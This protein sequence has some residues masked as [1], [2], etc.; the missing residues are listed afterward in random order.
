[1]LVCKFTMGVYQGVTIS[2]FFHVVLAGMH[3]PSK[4]VLDNNEKMAT[5]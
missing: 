5:V 3:F 1:M 4:I 2:H